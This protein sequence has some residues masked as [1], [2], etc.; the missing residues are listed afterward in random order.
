MPELIDA[1]EAAARL[2]VK[3][4]TV[5]A[6]VSRGQLDRQRAVDG[7]HSLFD[8]EE[9]DALSSGRRKKR[10]GEIDAA[11]ESSVTRVHTEHLGYRGEPLTRCVDRPFEE[12]ASHIWMTD[13]HEWSFSGSA[14]KTAQRVGKALSSDALYVD[15]LRASVAAAATTDSMRADLSPSAVAG[16]GR[17]LIA[18]M[19]MALPLLADDKNTAKDESS[20]A[21]QLWPRLSPIK[22]RRNDLALLNT[23]LILIADH[24]LATSTFA[25]RVAASVRADPYSVVTAGLGA[26]GGPLHG[27][28]S[29]H[30]HQLF[31]RTEELGSAQQAVSEVL[32]RGERVPGFGH[33]VY[34]DGDPRFEI[35]FG[36]IQQAYRND[37]RLAPMVELVKIVTTRTPVLPNI[38]Y[39]MGALTFFAGMAPDAGE[40][41]FAIGRT[42]G[43]LAHALEEYQEPP[44]RFRPQARYIGP[45]SLDS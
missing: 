6:Y 7:R 23:A 40:A 20:V 3:K 38:D 10:R 30:V 29:G 25:A 41:I 32:R 4:A 1:D 18:A 12:I 45:A 27:A 2:G 16:A 35:L 15:R 31:L 11:I 24:G 26:L 43:W 5:Y 28:A 17:Q 37:E 14:V 39:A 9:V 36:E 8:A 34:K 44:V 42:V 21:A 13:H 33:T 22:G 19:V